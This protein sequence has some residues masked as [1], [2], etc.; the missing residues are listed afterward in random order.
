M[1][2]K[3]IEPVPPVLPAELMFDERQPFDRLDSESRIEHAWFLSYCKMGAK[4]TYKE[5]SAYQEVGRETIQRA[6]GK[7]EWQVRVRAYD[8]Y[9]ATK[10]AHELETNQLEVREQHAEMIKSARDKLNARLA[11]LDAFAISPRDIPA[12]LEVIA[13]IERMTMGISDAPKKIELTGA[14]GGPIEVVENMTHEER[15]AR[16]DQLA[17]AIA[18]R[19]LEIAKRAAVIDGD[20]IEDA[21]VVEPDGVPE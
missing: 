13:K 11:T 16:M 4:R 8:E 17:E 3:E 14:N 20:V 10:R 21:D 6:S 19:Q 5:V 12:W 1:T 2:S 15:K 7:H 18:R 9:L